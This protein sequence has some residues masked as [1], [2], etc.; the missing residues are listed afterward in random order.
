MFAFLLLS[1]LR[2]DLCI[3]PTPTPPLAVLTWSAHHCCPERSVT[4]RKHGLTQ[5]DV[6]LICSN[7]SKLTQSQRLAAQSSQ[8]GEGFQGGEWDYAKREV[9]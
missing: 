2:I 8:L 4:K 9:R 3:P 6:L 7:I 5:D 1:A